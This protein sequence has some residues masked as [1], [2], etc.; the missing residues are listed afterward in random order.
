MIDFLK[1]IEV[2]QG[3]DDEQFQRLAELTELV[4]VPV[5][6]RIFAQGKPADAFYV[7]KSGQVKVVKDIGI[8]TKVL[9]HLGPGEFF[10]EMGLLA[11]TPRTASVDAAQP[12]EICKVSRLNFLAFVDQN[13][14]VKMKLRA[15]MARRT[16]DNLRSRL[17]G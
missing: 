13:P 14:L 15:V 8:E 4:S 3:L 7:V 16:T 2:F 12:T 5:N 6:A 1:T 10:G 17:G 11:N 9:A